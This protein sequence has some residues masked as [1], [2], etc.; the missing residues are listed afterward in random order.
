MSGL[1]A[2]A[3][4]I[5]QKRRAD[6]AALEET[7]SNKRQATEPEQASAN[8]LQEVSL[9]DL[10]RLRSRIRLAHCRPLFKIFY[11]VKLTVKKLVARRRLC[12]KRARSR[13]TP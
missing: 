11:R 4:L 1:K 10:K 9:A 8:A 6:R 7:R 5:E 2:I 3:A 13:E 12:G